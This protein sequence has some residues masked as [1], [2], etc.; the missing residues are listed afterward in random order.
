MSLDKEWQ[1]GSTPGLHPV[2]RGP[3]LMQ[4]HLANLKSEVFFPHP[5]PQPPT[6]QTWKVEEGTPR[7]PLRGQKTWNIKG[8][9]YQEN[10]EGGAKP[11]R[12]KRGVA[13][14]GHQQAGTK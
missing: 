14:G 3:A 11:P 2:G 4:R 10:M 5:H 8:P 1:S 13:A 9:T 7:L 12:E 6:R